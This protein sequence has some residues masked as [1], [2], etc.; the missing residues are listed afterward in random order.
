MK[1]RTGINSAS[2]P[3][4]TASR[5]LCRNRFD[6]VMTFRAITTFV[7]PGSSELP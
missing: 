7:K 1:R 5:L 4:K 2:E 6:A 3:E